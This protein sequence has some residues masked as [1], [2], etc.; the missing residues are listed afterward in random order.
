MNAIEELGKIFTVLRTMGADENWPCHVGSGDCLSPAIVAVHDEEQGEFLLCEKHIPDI[1]HFE[2]Q[3]RKM[4]FQD[5]KRLEEVIKS[6][7]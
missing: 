1:L 2:K 7:E 3:V 4:R 6:L 5:I